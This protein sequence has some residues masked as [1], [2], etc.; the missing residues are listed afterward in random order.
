MAE[1]NTNFTSCVY[2]INMKFCWLCWTIVLNATLS[3]I[4]VI[5]V[6][7]VLLMQEN[8]RPAVSH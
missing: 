3:N 8:N 5:R 4:S 1:V 2:N 7:L 6:V